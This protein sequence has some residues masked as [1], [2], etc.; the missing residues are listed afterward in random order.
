V[1][2]LDKEQRLSFTVNHF[3]CSWTANPR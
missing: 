2:P 3:T 1:G